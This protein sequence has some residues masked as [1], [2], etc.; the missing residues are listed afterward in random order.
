MGRLEVYWIDGLSK[1]RLGIMPRPRGGD[2]LAGDIETLGKLGA[3]VLVSLLMADEAAEV[4]LEGEAAAC[5]A[6]HIEFLSFPVVE[7]IRRSTG[8]SLPR[9]GE[10]EGGWSAR[11]PPFESW[12]AAGRARAGVKWGK[13]GG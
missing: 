2:G 5:V 13:L 12:P 9:W 4:K 3:K 6:N 10:W 8:G 1:G 7:G 11:F